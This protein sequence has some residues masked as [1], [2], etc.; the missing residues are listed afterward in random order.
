MYDL[1]V[2]VMA[3]PSCDQKKFA[4]GLKGNYKVSNPSLDPSNHGNWFQDEKL[5]VIQSEAMV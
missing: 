4:I 3:L 2:W 1:H 5:Q